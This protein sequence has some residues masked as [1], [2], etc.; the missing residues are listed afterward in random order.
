MAK[1][2][3]VEKELVAIKSEATMLTA[4]KDLHDSEEA[5]DKPRLG[6]TS[7]NTSIPNRTVK[8]IKTDEE[9]AEFLR[10]SLTKVED[11]NR[12][13]SYWNAYVLMSFSLQARTQIC[14]ILLERCK[15]LDVKPEDVWTSM[16]K[17]PEFYETWKNRL[18]SG[19][20][21][22]EEEEPVRLPSKNSSSAVDEDEHSPLPE[23]V[24]SEPATEL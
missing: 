3:N 23:A 6:F 12:A 22:E 9:R 13:R 4:W 14:S 5:T 18:N 7:V 15:E 11:L 1:K 19:V 8:T 21:T 10:K 16:L 2:L 20:I 17:D 24:D